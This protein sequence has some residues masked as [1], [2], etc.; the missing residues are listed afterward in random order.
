MPPQSQFNGGFQ[1]KCRHGHGWVSDCA[2]PG[3]S[4]EGLSSRLKSLAS[5]LSEVTNCAEPDF[6]QLAGSLK[7]L[8]GV[9][10]ELGKATAGNV[11]T[12]RETLESSRLTGE[13][14]LSEACLAE[15][16]AALDES[17][18]NL[19][20]L[21]GVGTELRRLQSLGAQVVRV[22]MF[23]NASS[24]AFAVESARTPTCHKAFAAFVEELRQQANKIRNLGG[25]IFDQSAVTE[26]D[27]KQVRDSISLDFEKLVDW[28]R[29]SENAVRTASTHMEQILQSSMG[30]LKEAERHAQT[31][32]QH[33]GDAVFYLQFG[34]IL[35]QKLEHVVMALAEEGEAI[36]NADESGQPVDSHRLT[37]Q[38]AQLEM[39][40]SE[41]QSTHAQLSKAFAGLGAETKNVLENIQVIG[42]GTSNHD[43][44]ESV[45]D[46]LKGSLLTLRT[47]QSHG[48]TLSKATGESSQRA[49]QASAQLAQH[50]GQ[51]QEINRE[52]HL[53]ALNAIVK[54]A[55]LG[56]EG[57]TLGVLSAH[58]HNIF[59]ESSGLVEETV[60]VLRKVTE[61]TD[62]TKSYESNS[63]AGKSEGLQRGIDCVSHI[64]SAFQNA[65][66][67]AQSLAHQQESLLAEAHHR[68]KFLRGLME[69]LGTLRRSV[70]EIAS[71][72]PTSATVESSSND[73]AAARYTIESEREV[74][75]RHSA[76]AVSVV[77]GGGLTL[78]ASQDNVDLFEGP[79]DVGR[80][81]QGENV[82]AAPAPGK[83]VST[84]AKSPGGD[85]D[86]NIEFF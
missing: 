29:Q 50:L 86:A 27:L 17:G 48:Q 57:V 62:S 39:M 11:T 61:L 52:M 82:H 42:K 47:L 12:I 20:A 56:D 35:R 15:L 76:G 5:E 14:G 64:Q 25:A 77:A 2:D 41:I 38:C 6:L 37:I 53:L 28:T 36:E 31:I 26:S 83:P 45:F 70:S 4:D 24:C 1:T 75:R 18:S 59:N 23:L 80:V 66:T 68:L 21:S 69:K 7:G 58:I 74:H 67:S 79:A 73:V 44:G 19:E 43:S 54:T 46:N 49:I 10:T 51:V 55:L 40:E 30:A 3:E 63:A 81:S 85:A 8:F 71:V 13:G 16:R 84:D 65:V 78:S 32:T 34:D 33:A 9:A 60:W 72:L 22:A